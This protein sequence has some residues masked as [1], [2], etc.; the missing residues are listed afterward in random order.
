MLSTL[1]AEASLSLSTRLHL[2]GMSPE[3]VLTQTGVSPLPWSLQ[4]L[5]LFFTDKQSLVRE[6]FALPQEVKHR[7]LLGALCPCSAEG[8][9]AWLS[10][11]PGL[12]QWHWEIGK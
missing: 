10:Q 12:L 3:P 7:V 5:D 9:R 1:C 11:A 6:P 8:A 4:N 2:V